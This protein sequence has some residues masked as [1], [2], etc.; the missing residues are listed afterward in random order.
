MNSVL[1]LTTTKFTS[2]VKVQSVPFSIEISTH[3]DQ[4]IMK[5]C[6]LQRCLK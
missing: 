3:D 1:K 2:E 6:Q 4:V 5:K